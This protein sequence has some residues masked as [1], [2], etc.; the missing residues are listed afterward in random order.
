MSEQPS[1]RRKLVVRL[2]VLGAIVLA[3]VIALAVW[4]D[5]FA[6]TRDGVI[7][8]KTMEAGQPTL[9]VRLQDGTVERVGVSADV[10]RDVSSDWPV[11]IKGRS[12]LAKSPDGTRQVMSGEW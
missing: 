12:V 6:S 9:V 5:V 7:V 10:Y 11:K 8:E 1:G 3:V 2:A 4:T